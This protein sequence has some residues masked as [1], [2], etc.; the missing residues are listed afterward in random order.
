MIVQGAN[1][2]KKIDSIENALGYLFGLFLIY[3]KWEEKK[4][5]LNAVKIQIPLSGQHL[6]HEEILDNIIKKL[7]QE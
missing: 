4:N 2:E 6:A 7:Q 5:E 1:E 3:G